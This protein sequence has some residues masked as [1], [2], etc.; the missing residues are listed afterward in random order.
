MRIFFSN[1]SQLANE[2]DI[3]GM[4]RLTADDRFIL[5]T[6]ENCN[7]P[8]AV[9][10]ALKDVLPEP[11]FYAMPDEV[12]TEQLALF[13]GLCAWRGNCE[14]YLITKKPENMATLDDF[15]MPFDQGT[16]TVHVCESFSAA[17]PIDSHIPA[18]AEFKRIL[19]AVSHGNGLLNQYSDII[20]EA[21]RNTPESMLLSVEMQLQMRMDKDM[22]ADIFELV[23][24]HMDTLWSIAQKDAA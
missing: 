13:M 14:M 12:S 24:D 3:E 1:I 17:C 21:V 16:A 2:D 11:E 23:K 20:E 19:S 8:V 15:E 6:D 5:L 4:K 22:A 10:Q 18:S 9:H 7:M